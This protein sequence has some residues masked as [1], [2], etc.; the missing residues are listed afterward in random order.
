MIESVGKKAD[1]QRK[2]HESNTKGHGNDNNR[3]TVASLQ[4]RLQQGR[5]M[6][7]K[8]IEPASKQRPCVLANPGG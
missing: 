3:L 6:R 5:F 1:E 2:R 4:L 8:P 7:V